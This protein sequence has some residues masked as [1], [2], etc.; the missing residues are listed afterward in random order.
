MLA[1][2]IE[3]ASWTENQQAYFTTLRQSDFL[4]PA[5]VGTHHET[6]ASIVNGT[7]RALPAEEDTTAQS[8]K[9]AKLDSQETCY[10]HRDLLEDETDVHQYTIYNI[11]A[12]SPIR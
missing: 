7:K 6:S 9:K 4:N 10:Q 5:L 12:T 1:R 3:E 8:S 11:S 2:P